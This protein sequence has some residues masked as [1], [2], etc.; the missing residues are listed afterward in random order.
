M[1]SQVLFL[2]LLILMSLKSN[3]VST[4]YRAIYDFEYTKDSINSTTGKDILFLEISEKSSF[5][6]SYYTYQSDS[7]RST[8]NGRAIWRELF[9]AAIKKDGINATSFPHKRSNFKITKIDGNDTIFVKDVIDTDVFQYATSKKELNWQITDSL[10]VINGYESYQ[11]TCNYHGREWIVWFT[12]NIPFN[13]GPWVF[14]D[15][16][17]LII[18]AH[19]KDNLF[20]FTLIGFTSNKNSKK[21]WTERGKITNRKEFLKKKYQ[22]LNNL[23]SVLKAEIGINISSGKDTRYLYGLEPDF[24]K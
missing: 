9:S 22:Y 10:K 21:D 17:G 4:D 13:D 20:S 19:D 14:C 3:A 7:L 18:E 6:F 16:P 2:A 12:P 5:C 15:L 24:L 11:A 8:P 23:N 1:K